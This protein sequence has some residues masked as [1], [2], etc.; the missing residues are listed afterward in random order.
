MAKR[1]QPWSKER[2]ALALKGEMDIPSLRSTVRGFGAADGYDL[3]SFGTW[4]ASQKR[5]V[6]DYTKR[7]HFLLAQERAIVYPRSAKSNDMLQTAFH[8]DMK[9]KMFKAV[10]VPYVQPIVS[11]GKKEKP[12]YKITST[13]ITITNGSNRRHVVLFDQVA[14]ATDAKQE[15]AR[16][17]HELRMCRLFYVQVDEFQTL[18]GMDAGTIQSKVLK[19]VQR[20]NGVTTLPKFSR[21]YGDDPRSHFYQD[22]LTGIVGY[23]FSDIDARE[24]GRKIV[25]GMN[26]AKQRRKASD[27]SIKKKT[28]RKHVKNAS[29]V[30]GR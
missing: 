2:Y 23:E 21:H 25:A 4:T 5:R 16:V 13:G 22:W 14:L 27:N 10:F 6:R 29:K 8:G 20:Y 28:T 19:L 3:R 9:S 11:T 7:V 24:M 15:I 17:T 12:H 18:N 26:A 30:G 1:K